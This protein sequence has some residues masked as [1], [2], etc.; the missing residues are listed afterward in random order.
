MG[1]SII[2]A[3]PPW[4]YRDKANAGQRGASH[5]YPCMT[6][7]EIIL[8]P[9]EEIAS[10]DSVLFLWAT[11]PLI[12][13]AQAVMEAWGFEYKTFGF[14]WV[15]T[16][17]AGKP[18]GGGMGH[19]TRANVE[20]CLLGAR[21]KY[22]QREDKGIRQVVMAPKGRH[23]AKPPEVRDRIVQLYGDLP[24]LEMFARKR[25]DGWHC[26]G[27]EIPDADVV[28]GGEGAA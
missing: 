20:P 27:D 22:I 2:Y 13:H 23:S 24:R 17:K 4:T 5:K 12:D 8:L 16:T 21:G 25:A 19:Y 1:Y 28:F 7:D 18:H 14:L 10:E 26:H 11:P 9:V 6:L 3:D 15:K